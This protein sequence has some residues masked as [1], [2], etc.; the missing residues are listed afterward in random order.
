M[1]ISSTIPTRPILKRLL[2]LLHDYWFRSSFICLWLFFLFF[3]KQPFYTRHFKQTRLNLS[4]KGLTASRQIHPSVPSCT[5][6]DCGASRIEGRDREIPG[7]DSSSPTSEVPYI[8]QSQG[9]HNTQ[10]AS[11]EG[12]V[13][14]KSLYVDKSFTQQSISSRDEDKARKRRHTVLISC[15]RTWPCWHVLLSCCDKVTETAAT[16]CWV[17]EYVCIETDACVVHFGKTT[18]YQKH[19]EHVNIDK[20]KWRSFECNFKFDELDGQTLINIDM[21]TVGIMRRLS[22]KEN[23]R[24]KTFAQTKAP[25]LR[26]GLPVWTNSSKLLLKNNHRCSGGQNKV[27]SEKS[28]SMFG[29]RCTLFCQQSVAGTI[30]WHTWHGRSENY[31]R[32]PTGPGEFREEKLEAKVFS[33]RRSSSGT[34][35]NSASSIWRWHW[36]QWRKYC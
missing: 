10:V 3:S 18:L 23:I 24:L 21:K 19:Q 34:L 26:F 2:F 32:P 31:K 13:K 35:L 6:T 33:V 5:L 12:K 7:A 17:G 1:L 28:L 11:P 27:M 9:Q 15:V 8:S 29:W 14:R 36:R 20:Q 25:D 4:S 16:Q 30:H 22:K